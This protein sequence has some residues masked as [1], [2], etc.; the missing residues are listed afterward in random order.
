VPHDSHDL[1]T[2]PKCSSHLTSSERPRDGVCRVAVFL[3]TLFASAPLYADPISLSLRMTITEISDSAGLLRGLISTPLSVGDSFDASMRFE[4]VG[5]D[6]AQS[7]D[8]LVQLGSGVFV[9]SLDTLLQFDES[10]SAVA[11]NTSVIGDFVF[12]AFNVAGPGLGH[13]EAEIAFRDPS[14]RALSQAQFPRSLD[15][16]A[17]FPV[18][19][20]QL[21][22]FDRFADLRLTIAADV[23]V[24]GAE[25]PVPEPATILLLGSGCAAAWV[26]RRRRRR[27][28]SHNL[29]P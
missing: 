20:F 28:G 7:P 12:F 14:G 3:V 4:P 9:P 13:A 16:F 27:T 23:H 8:V 1:S 5:P 18:R 24:V 15:A 22:G 6:L 25:A 21:L 19:D 26:A 10:F 11:L 2:P 17:A 29:L